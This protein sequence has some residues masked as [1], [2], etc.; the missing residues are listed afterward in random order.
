MPDDNNIHTTEISYPKEEVSDIIWLQSTLHFQMKTVYKFCYLYLSGRLGCWFPICL[1]NLKGLE[2]CFVSNLVSVWQ[3]KPF[4]GYHI[5][6]WTPVPNYIC[7]RES[8]WPTDALYVIWQHLATGF[9][10]KS[11]LNV[12][13]HLP[14]LTLCTFSIV[15]ATDPDIRSE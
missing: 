7:K 10:E 3:M 14:I 12:L 5:Y 11:G 4:N 1:A 8:F 6:P 15:W 9:W 2:G 13:H